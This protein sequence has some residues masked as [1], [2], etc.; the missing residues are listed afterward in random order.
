MYSQR[1]LEPAE[2]LNYEPGIF[3]SE[4]ILAE[5]FALLG[6]YP[7]SLEY[8]FKALA[9]AKQFNHPLKLCY[10]NGGLAACYYHIGDYNTGIKYTREVI[11]IM[12]PMNRSDMYWMWIEM[13]KAF[14]RIGQPDSALLFAKK[15]YE[16]IKVIPSAFVNSA[17]AP[18]LANAY[19]GKANYDS[20]LLYYRRGV[21]FSIKSHTQI[22]LI[23]NYYGIAEVYKSKNNPDSALWVF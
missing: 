22:H 21:S 10:G 2:R 6:N 18:V 12:E 13:S 1:A 20:A 16:K 7:L 19:A 15:A 4:I 9:L 11:K 23:D 17:M 5:S 3:W 14:H 8:N